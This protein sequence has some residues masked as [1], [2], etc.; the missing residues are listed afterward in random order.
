[1][2]DQ[3]FICEER[4]PGGP[5]DI[6]FEYRGLNFTVFKNGTKC[7]DCVESRYQ[8]L[9]DELNPKLL[10]LGE[11]GFQVNWSSYEDRSRQTDLLQA[12]DVLSHERQGNWEIMAP[13]PVALL[14]R[15]SGM[16]ELYFTS[17]EEAEGYARA[18]RAN[19]QF[20]WELRHIGEVISKDEVLGAKVP[21]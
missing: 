9:F 4:E 7:S 20:R 2:S 13:G 18:T 3:C 5:Q 15:S 17:R 11:G 14:P 21:S 8:Q 12:L 6:I 19:T 16:G 10:E 1:M